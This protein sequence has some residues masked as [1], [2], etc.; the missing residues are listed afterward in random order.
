MEARRKPDGEGVRR[1]VRVGNS[2]PELN[3]AIRER[4]GGTQSDRND[5]R[6]TTD[7]SGIENKKKGRV[8]ED[9]FRLNREAATTTNR[10][11]STVTYSRTRTRSGWIA[12]RTPRSLLSQP[13]SCV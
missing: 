4:E 5:G 1:A 7:D 3:G 13:N 6:Q 9:T 12:L 2:N 11:Y 10:K 8:A